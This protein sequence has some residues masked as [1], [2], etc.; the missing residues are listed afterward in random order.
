MIEDEFV[1]VALNAARDVLRPPLSIER[2]QPLLYQVLVDNRLNIQVNPKKLKR[3][4]SAFQ[5]DLCVFEAVEP[6][7]LLPRVVFEFKAGMSTHDVLTYT[8]KAR[9]HKQVYPYLRYGLV[10]ARD[11]K[12]HRK[13]FIHNDALD[14][15][16]A[17]GAYAEDPARLRE[18]FRELITAEVA[19][20]R[21]LE[22]A[23]FGELTADLFR[24]EVILRTSADTALDEAFGSWSDHTEDGVDYQRRLRSEWD[25]RD[26]RISAGLETNADLRN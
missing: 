19:A 15:C 1:E 9:K 4:Q 12:L 11:F 6:D 23:A 25:D 13:F 21:R 7:V 20:S 26:A 5:T 17:A 18:V 22:Q 24:T 16:V 3:G 2:H 10:V 8:T 14:F